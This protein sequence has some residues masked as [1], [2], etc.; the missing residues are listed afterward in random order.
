MRPNV[1]AIALLHIQ[2]VFLFLFSTDPGMAVPEDTLPQRV[3]NQVERF[4][5]IAYTTGAL[6]SCLTGND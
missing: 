2:V 3:V 6:F 4:F 5:S 1:H